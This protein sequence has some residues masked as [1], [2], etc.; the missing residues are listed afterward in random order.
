MC[1]SRAQEKVFCDVTRNIEKERTG[2][3][4]AMDV[5]A[6]GEETSVFDLVSRKRV[7]CVLNS[8]CSAGQSRLHQ[9]EGSAT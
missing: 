5:S 8:G 9:S 3:G 6:H 2:R 4:V 1:V 7:R